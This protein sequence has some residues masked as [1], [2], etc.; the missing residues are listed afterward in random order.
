MVSTSN[1]RDTRTGTPPLSRS[2][3]VRL[4]KFI[5]NIFN[6]CSEDKYKITVLNQYAGVDR[7]PFR[8]F[9]PEIDPSVYLSILRYF[10]TLMSSLLRQTPLVKRQMVFLVEEKTLIILTRWCPVTIYVSTSIR[11]YP[12]R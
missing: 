2:D 5:H 12:S 3:S 6:V 11:L 1:G 7:R 9:I 10:E 4:I 8:P